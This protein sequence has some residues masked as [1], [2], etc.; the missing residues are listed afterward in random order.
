MPST[1]ASKTVE[2]DREFV[3]EAIAHLLAADLVLVS[4]NDAI[5]SEAGDI[6]AEAGATLR[7]E[8][9]GHIEDESWLTDPDEVEIHARSSEIAATALE[10]LAKRELEKLKEDELEKRFPPMSRIKGYRDVAKR[11]REQGTVDVGWREDA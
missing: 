4:L 7:D 3:M 5:D 8:A 6:F 11:T 9:L 2:V 10:R 1:T